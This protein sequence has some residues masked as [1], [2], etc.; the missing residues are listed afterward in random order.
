MA[1]TLIS[2]FARSARNAFSVCAMVRAQFAVVASLFLLPRHSSHRNDIYNALWAMVFGFATLNILS[3]AARHFEPNRRGLTFG[4]LLAV[5]VVLMS[6]V[7]L[8]WEILNLIH[9]FPIQLRH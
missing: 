3:L 8:G 7:L 1:V 9:I 4:E 2:G 6:I 5:L